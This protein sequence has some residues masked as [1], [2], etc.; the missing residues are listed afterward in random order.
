MEIPEL[1]VR[2]NFHY[3]Q[4]FLQ[5]FRVIL[6]K[7][8]SRIPRVE[9]EEM[10]PLVDLVMRRTHLASDHLM[11]AATKVPKTLKVIPEAGKK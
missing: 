4:I 2:A 9:L 11:K 10:G 1:M 6:K 3:K 7:S 5:N 8:G